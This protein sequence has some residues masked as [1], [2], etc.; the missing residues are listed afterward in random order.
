MIP[1]RR[2]TAR[3]RW[4]RRSPIPTGRR[5]VPV[6]PMTATAAATAATAAAPATARVPAP[7]RGPAPAR[8][9]AL[10][11]VRG[12]RARRTVDCLR[13]EMPTLRQPSESWVSARSWPVSSGGSS[14]TI[15][16]R[17]PSNP[18]RLAPACP[19]AKTVTYAA[20]V[21]AHPSHR[22]SARRKHSVRNRVDGGA[23]M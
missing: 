14:R 20:A 9:E 13:R 10:A 4:A 22:P 12:P 18:C 7:E 21:R 11:R 19:P 8:V 15:E 23:T 1:T 2:P 16:V 5:A 17:I 3:S 6:G